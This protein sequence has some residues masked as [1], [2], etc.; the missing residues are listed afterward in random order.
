M[1]YNKVESKTNVHLD[2]TPKAKEDKLVDREPPKK[3][4]S[5]KVKKQKKG[6]MERFVVAIIGPDG[7]PAIGSYL[8]KE[9]IGPSLLQLTAESLKSGIDMIA[10]KN[11][12]AP[13]VTHANPRVPVRPQTNYAA[14]YH[15]PTAMVTS[16]PA[17][18]EKGR[19]VPTRARVEEF[20][21][22]DRN[23]AFQV[24][25]ALKAQAF[26]FN[27]ATLADYYDMIEVPSEYTHHGYGWTAEDLE[28][29]TLM[30]TRGGT[31][32]KFPPARVL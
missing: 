21:I 24:V 16:T 23:E 10:Y 5:G 26:G 30:P 12:G 7:L 11:Q 27:H 25:E 14:Q 4:V 9:V 22:A 15:S 17:P 8:L 20:I 28:K 18:V 3:V 19:V 31:I 6:L 1:D 2:V 29:V 32:I 13:N